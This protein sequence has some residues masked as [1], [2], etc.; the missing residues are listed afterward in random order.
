MLHYHALYLQCSQADTQ[1][2]CGKLHNSKDHDDSSK[3]S[4]AR[5][6]APHFPHFLTRQNYYKVATGKR[7]EGVAHKACCAISQKHNASSQRVTGRG[8][9]LACSRSEEPSTMRG[10]PCRQGGAHAAAAC[11]SA[12]IT[13]RAT[14]SN[15]CHCASPRRCRNLVNKNIALRDVDP[16]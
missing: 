4:R 13:S 14:A 6:I 2:L 15:R 10:V 7:R 12:T 3:E 5:A 8:E 1:V 9:A 16:E 11:S